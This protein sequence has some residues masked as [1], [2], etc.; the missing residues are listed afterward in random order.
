MANDAAG[1]FV[2]DVLIYDPSCGK[3]AD[4]DDK[5]GCTTDTCNVATGKCA[6][7]AGACD[8]K[9]PCTTDTCDKA[10]KQC[11]HDQADPKCCSDK[12]VFSQP[13]ES[14]NGKL[15]SDWTLKFK[16]GNAQGGMGSPYD[17]TINWNEI[18]RAHV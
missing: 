2:D 14:N 10:S 18:G 8:D 3:D 5:N 4:C 16:T 9:N 11:K 1:P 7:A 6:F 13:W 17:K 15:P 12:S